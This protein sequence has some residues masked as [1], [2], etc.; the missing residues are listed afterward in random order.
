MEALIDKKIILTPADEKTNILVPFTVTKDYEKLVID[1]TYSPKELGDCPKAMELIEENLRKDTGE[2]RPLYP[3]YKEFLPLK[4]LVTL[5]LDGPEGYI[6][7]AHRQ[8]DVQHHIISHDFSS[9]GFQKS[10][11]RKGEWLVYLNVHALVTDECE[12]ILKI[13]GGNGDE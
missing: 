3:D 1:Y 13:Q 11:I 2:D 5:S 7:A 9:R 10:E 6:G 8:D 4:N 12:C